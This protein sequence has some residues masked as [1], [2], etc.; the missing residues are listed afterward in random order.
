[1]N[2]PNACLVQIL[3]A[4]DLCV[5][6]HCTYNLLRDLEFKIGDPIHAI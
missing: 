1:M 4:M 3:V 2:L 6:S 5:I